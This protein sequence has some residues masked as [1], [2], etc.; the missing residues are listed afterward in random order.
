MQLLR[1]LQA[2]LAVCGA[3]SWQTEGVLLGSGLL[4]R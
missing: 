3:G 4:M 2:A 1:V